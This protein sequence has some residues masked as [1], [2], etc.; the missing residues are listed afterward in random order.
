MLLKK[1]YASKIQCKICNE[2]DVQIV[3][4]VDRRNK[5]LCTVICTGC[6]LVRT[7][8]VPTK[9]DLDLYYAQHYRADYKKT[10]RPKI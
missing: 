6:G 1:I 4:L 2:S 9:T 8:P 10:L 7:D 5:P 3:S